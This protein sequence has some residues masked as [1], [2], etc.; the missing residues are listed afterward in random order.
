M[1]RPSS[2]YHVMRQPVP[3]SNPQISF[4][5]HSIIERTIPTRS[6]RESQPSEAFSHFPFFLLK[7]DRKSCPTKCRIEAGRGFSWGSWGRQ[8]VIGF[9]LA[10]LTR[11]LPVCRPLRVVLV[12]GLCAKL[13]HLLIVSRADPALGWSCRRCLAESLGQSDS[14]AGW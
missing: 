12:V 5:T 13:A 14:D 8:F 9:P 1:L 4:V 11:D 2:C 3:H 7:A 6:A 10:P